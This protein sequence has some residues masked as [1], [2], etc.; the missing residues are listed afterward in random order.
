VAAIAR[1][2]AATG[3]PAVLL[4][5]VFLVAFNLRTTPASLPPLLGE[6]QPDLRLSS[7]AAGLLTA[8]PVLCMALCSPPAQRVA[9]RLGRETTLLAALGLIAGGTLARGAPGLLF[10]G[11]V[12]AGIGVATAG[13]ILPAIV[14]D[15]FARRPAAATA[16]YSVPMM[17]GAAVSPALAVPIRDALGTWQGSLAAW[18]IPAALAALAWLPITRARRHGEPAPAHGRL[19]LRSKPAWLLAAFMSAQSALAYAYIGWLPAAYESRGWPPARAGALLGTLQLAQLVTA[20]TLPLV[21]ERSADRRPAMLAAGVCT[22]TGASLLVAAP[23]LAWPATVIL[24]LGLG[25][26]FTLGLVVMTDLAASPAAASQLAAMTFLVCYLVA[27]VAPVAV[28]ALHDLS[29][30]FAVPF[31]ALVIVAAGQLSLAT[32]LGPRRRV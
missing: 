23:H 15:R 4:G 14:K 25:G 28:G 5:A 30:T 19:P 27:S 20:L 18:A 31:G 32:R 11:T 6:I 24:G 9:H 26:G 2:V 16:A 3:R 1:P 8:L 12:L 22:L 29:G 7:A 21:T 17:L 13:V 10:A